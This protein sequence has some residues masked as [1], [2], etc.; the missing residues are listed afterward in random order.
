MTPCCGEGVW[1]TPAQGTLLREH[2][3]LELWPG[4]GHGAM[5]PTQLLG[6]VLPLTCLC[7]AGFGPTL[8]KACSI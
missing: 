5:T 4:A 8:L 3:S 2:S 1:W 6:L 7:L